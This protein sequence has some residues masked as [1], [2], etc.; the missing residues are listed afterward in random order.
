MYRHIIEG[1]EQEKQKANTSCQT[2]LIN[3]H[4]NTDSRCQY[5]HEIDST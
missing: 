2:Y 3:I 1:R 4:A 5:L